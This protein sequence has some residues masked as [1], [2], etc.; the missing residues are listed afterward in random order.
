M[1]KSRVTKI[2]QNGTICLFLQAFHDIHCPSGDKT[3][4]PSGGKTPP[5][6]RGGGSKSRRGFPPTYHSARETKGHY[7]RRTANRRG[8]TPPV[9]VRPPPPLRGS[10]PCEAQFWHP[11]GKQKGRYDPP[12]GEQNGHYGRRMENRRGVTS[13]AEFVKSP[14][15]F[16]CPKKGLNLCKPPS[17]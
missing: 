13:R 14:P 11:H 4:C 5:P 2:S 3:D 8:V 9:G 16:D 10:S 15:N 17:R 12:H 6:C 7:D 1:R